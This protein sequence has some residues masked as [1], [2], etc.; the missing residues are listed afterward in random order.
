[1]SKSPRALSLAEWQSATQQQLRA[2]RIARTQ[3]ILR[4]SQKASK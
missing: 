2:E 3:A 1:M 4:A